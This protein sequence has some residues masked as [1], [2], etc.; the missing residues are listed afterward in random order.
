MSEYGYGHT[1]R[2]LELI[3]A[4]L[5][6][7]PDIKIDIRTKISDIIISQNKDFIKQ[8]E[9]GDLV[10]GIW[11][12]GLSHQNQFNLN[13]EEID[14]TANDLQT[15]FN[16][17]HDELVKSEAELAKKDEI[18][19]II[20]DIPSYAFEIADKS[21]I[22]SVG[23][24]DF[25]WNIIYEPFAS[26]NP[27]FKQVISRL[28]ESYSKMDLLIHLS[29]DIPIPEEVDS[30]KINFVCRK[31][32]HSASSTK[33]ALGLDKKKVII[34]IG[35]RAK[36]LKISR[37]MLEEFKNVQFISHQNIPGVYQ[38][39]INSNNYTHIDVINAS[40]LV[41]GK[42]GYSLL[43]DLLATK[44]ALLWVDRDDFAEDEYL[45]RPM[46][47]YLPYCHH[48]KRSEYISGDWSKHIDHFLEVKKD[49]NFKNTSQ[50]RI[51][52]ADQAAHIIMKRF[53]G[54]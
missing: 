21:G 38:F 49:G 31:P 18:D 28:N 27:I 37:S 43:G 8:I 42:P 22:K 2:S 34:L 12:G 33:K 52:G 35:M 23:F 45:V 36:E 6:R 39:D 13:D 44:K 30:E 4:I 41:I 5:K 14:Q 9:I 46:N 32:T 25:L 15:F 16:S 48:M 19:L 40:D 24:S 1:I 3:R 11:S 51:N 20:S 10:T 26:K 47:K 7:D 54:Y 53:L 29:P 50:Y 17:F